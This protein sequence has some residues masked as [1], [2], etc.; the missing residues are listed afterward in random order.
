MADTRGHGFVKRRPKFVTVRYYDH[1]A[2]A[3][4]WAEPK[5]SE[6]LKP[7]RVEARGWIIGENDTMLELSAQRPMDAD[8]NEWGQPMRIVK[9]VIFYRSDEKP[10]KAAEVPQP[11]P[12]TP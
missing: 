4:T 9:A 11:C 8:D 5:T 12:S 7:A 6:E 1:H 3:D 10:P 2:S